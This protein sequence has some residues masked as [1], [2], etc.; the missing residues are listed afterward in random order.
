MAADPQDPKTLWQDQ[1]PEA[2]LV[3]LEQIHDFA[4]RFDRKTRFTPAGVALCILI[5]GFIT[6]QM[7]LGA[8]DTLHRATTILF[9]AGQVGCYFLIYR[10][11]FPSRDP[12]EPVS[13]Y[14]R[15]RMVGRLSY[16]RGGLSVVLLP[17]APFVLVGGYQVLSRSDR[18]LWVKL[19][20]FALMAATMVFVTVRARTGAKKMSAQL[21]EL[22]EL[23]KH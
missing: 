4:R 1:E 5:V 11:L 18:P 19:L 20:P 2:D 12:A 23:M 16:L 10:V 22:D 21:R 6:G 14:L 17:L 7:W 13:A 3:T 9:A 8:H 15:R